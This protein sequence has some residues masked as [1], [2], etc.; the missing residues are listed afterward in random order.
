MRIEDQAPPNGLLISHDTYRI[1]RGIFDITPLEPIIAKGFEHSVPVYLVRGAKV[2]SFGFKT[3]WV[4]GIET[5]MVGRE[6][7]L[8]LL[9]QAGLAYPR[10][11]MDGYHFTDFVGY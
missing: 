3:H 7:E 10:F 5:R 8:Y 11:A 4:E 1:V 9:K 2:R 6:N